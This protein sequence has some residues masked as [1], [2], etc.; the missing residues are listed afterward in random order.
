MLKM[1][2][3]FSDLTKLNWLDWSTNWCDENQFF[4]YIFFRRITLWV[5]YVF[6]WKNTI[7]VKQN[8]SN[9][10]LWS[11]YT[12]HRPAKIHKPEANILY[13]QTLQ[14]DDDMNNIFTWVDLLSDLQTLI[15]INM[16]KFIIINK[17]NNE[18]INY[19]IN[20]YWIL[21]IHK[22]RIPFVIHSSCEFCVT[23]FSWRFAKIWVSITVFFDWFVM[24]NC[25]PDT[26][27]TRGL[28][29]DILLFLYK[30]LYTPGF[31]RWILFLWSSWDF[32]ETLGVSR[33]SRDVIFL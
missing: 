17:H 1:L 25:D 27:N 23:L 10:L 20:N 7:H 16:L 19:H 4:I 3:F 2:Y 13:I 9:I 24:D 18:D 26:G 15:Y 31:L 30:I 14:R 11:I 22:W 12:L 6:K 28:S 5:Y 8:R 32:L 33:Q 29:Y 21:T